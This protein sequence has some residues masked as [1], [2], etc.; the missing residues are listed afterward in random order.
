MQ[1]KADTITITKGF[2]ANLIR[3]SEQLKILKEFVRSENT[4]TKTEIINL[5]Y[6]M[7]VVGEK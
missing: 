7:E 5:I 2:Y 6:A 3:Q 4:I 1:C